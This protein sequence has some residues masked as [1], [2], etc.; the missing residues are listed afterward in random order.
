MYRTLV[1]ARNSTLNSLPN[2]ANEYQNVKITK[3]KFKKEKSNKNKHKSKCS[4][5]RKQGKKDI[6]TD[7]FAI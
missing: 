5:K 6:K 3:S 4:F 7:I 1:T 2:L